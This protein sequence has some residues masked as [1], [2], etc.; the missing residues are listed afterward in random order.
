MTALA[1]VEREPTLDDLATTIERE[2]SLVEN[3]A[4][5]VVEHSIRAGVALLEAK[6][7]VDRGG[8]GSW[9]KWLALNCP[10]SAGV[11]RAYMRIAAYQDVVHASGAESI[12]AARRAL[13]GHESLPYRPGHDQ[14]KSRAVELCAGGMSPTDAADL[15]DVPRTTLACWVN[16]SIAQKHRDRSRERYRRRVAEKRAFEAQ[17]QEKAVKRA[18]KKAGVAHQE[19]YHMAERMQDVLA[20]AQ[21]EAT[22]SEA[23]EAL[24]L[25]W[26]H[27]TR[28][29]DQIVRALPL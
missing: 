14:L 17:E 18:I 27:W 15:L 4:A 10:Q 6:E 20:Q 8:Y 13:K 21:R 1:R 22:D 9:R 25:A 24:S 11:A 28:M 23:K 12:I 19:A 26:G 29:R 2:H 16:P 3:A 7:I 5:G